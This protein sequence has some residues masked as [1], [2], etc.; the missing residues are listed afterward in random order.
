MKRVGSDPGPRPGIPGRRLWNLAAAGIVL[1]AAGAAVWNP[2]SPFAMDRANSAYLTGDQ[3][4]ALRVY[5]QIADGWHRPATRQTAAERAALLHLEAGSDVAAVNRLRQAITLA[6]GDARASLQE[7]LATVYADHFLDH[8]RAAQ[9]LLEASETT[10][11]VDLSVA[12]AR[13]FDRAEAWTDAQDAWNGVL[14]R[15]VEPGARAEAES[16]LLRAARHGDTTDGK[17]AE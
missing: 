11:R 3:E 13:E 7:R 8:R 14:P 9:L 5:E 17:E 6:D 15:L 12:A 16:G 1:L 4:T 2:I 10:G